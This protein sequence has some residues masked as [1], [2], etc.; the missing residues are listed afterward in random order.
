MNRP[1]LA[2]C[3]D[4]VYGPGACT[5]TGLLLQS[6]LPH[7]PNATAAYTTRTYHARGRTLTVTAPD[8]SATLYGYAG[9][10]TTM[11][12]AAGNL[13]VERHQL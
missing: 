5:P 10:K 13:L 2:T 12:D 9:N 3:A 7:R 1:R 6:S 4:S 8:C 11:T